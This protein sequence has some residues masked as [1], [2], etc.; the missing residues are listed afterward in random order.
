MTSYLQYIELGN[1]YLVSLEA[2]RKPAFADWLRVL[3]SVFG[4]TAIAIIII[5]LLI[6]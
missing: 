4:T 2:K 3:S 6:E 5:D 1:D